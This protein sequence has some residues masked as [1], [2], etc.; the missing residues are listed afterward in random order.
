[1]SLILYSAYFHKKERTE[2]KVY[3]NDNHDP[4]SFCC[5]KHCYVLKYDPLA[6]TIVVHTTPHTR[7]NLFFWLL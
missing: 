4:V 2:A 6:H 1:M 3:V 7:N 5:Y